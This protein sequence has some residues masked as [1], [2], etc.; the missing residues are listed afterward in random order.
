MFQPA[1]ER[2]QTQYHLIILRCRRHGPDEKTSLHERGGHRGRVGDWLAQRGISTLWGNRRVHGRCWSRCGCW[3]TEGGGAHVCLDAAITLQPRAA[4]ADAGFSLRNYLVIRFAQKRHY[5][6]DPLAFLAQALR[7]GGGGG[8]QH[9]LGA[10]DRRDVQRAFD[11]ASSPICCRSACKR[12]RVCRTGIGARNISSVHWTSAMRRLLPETAFVALPDCAHAEFVAG[13]PGG[14][15][16][17]AGRD[18]RAG[19]KRYLK[20]QRPVQERFPHRALF[21]L[22][23]VP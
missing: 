5:G 3:R 21:S 7:S 1:A 15:C 11:S 23:I 13:Q 6:A 22:F 2:L 16:R 8:C 18:A 12:R 9:D 20:N 4:V 19:R 17:A 10:M 14:F